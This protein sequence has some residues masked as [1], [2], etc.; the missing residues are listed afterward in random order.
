MKKLT[1]LRGATQVLNEE[2]DIVLQLAA[3]YDALL[4]ENQFKEEDVV[5]IIFSVTS[6]I[7][8]K[9]PAAALRASGRASAT[10]LFS[11]LE[12]PS[13]SLPRV[14]RVLIH[15]YLE[16]ACFLR[17]I[18]RNGAEILRP[19]FSAPPPPKD[20][21][22]LAGKQDEG[23]YQDAVRMTQSQ[24]D[25]LEMAAFLAEKNG[26]VRVTALAAELGFSKA[27][28]SAALKMLEEKDL[29]KH[30]RYGTVQLT[31]KGRTLA[32]EIREK[33]DLLKKFLCDTRGVAAGIAEKDACKMEHILSEETFIKLR[34]FVARSEKLV[35]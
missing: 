14:I 1:A 19:D 31:N 4:Q 8:V 26:E 10:A 21:G 29:I 35:K 25:Y 18:Y 17:H 13:S 27:S 7:T 32:A 22:K 23:W 3:L 2:N 33:H 24:E 34:A 15:C 9:N 30:E 6:D 5:S 11:T 28:V 12:P 20:S 16:E